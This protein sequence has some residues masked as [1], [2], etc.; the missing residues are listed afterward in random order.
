M[1]PKEEGEFVDP[2]GSEEKTHEVEIPPIDINQNEV[3]RVQ[4]ELAEAKDKF[5]RIA[6]EFEN[7]R[8]RW[9]R[10]RADIHKY[11]LEQILQDLLPVLDSFEKA[12]AE[13]QNGGEAILEGV[14]L[15]QKQLQDVLVRHGLCS[16]EAIGKPFDP[17]IHQAVHRSEGDVDGDQVKEEYRK[18]YTLN[19]RLIRPAMVS[20]VVPASGEGQIQDRGT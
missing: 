12:T 16:V 10:E 19:G 7:A 20:V 14:K 8:R 15:V 5:M 1:M 13:G 4:Q 6:A 11:G 2:N 18:G 17:Q 3:V 9:D